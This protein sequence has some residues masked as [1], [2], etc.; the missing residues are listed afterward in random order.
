MNWY[1]VLPALID[2]QVWVAG[3]GRTGK[4]VIQA[5]RRLGAEIVLI[6][7]NSNEVPDNVNRL[8]AVPQKI[9]ADLIVTSPGWRPDHELFQAAARASVKVIGDVELAWLVD[10]AQ[11]QRNHRPPLKWLAVTG[12]NGKTTTVEMLESILKAGGIS[13]VACGNVGLPVIDAVM[14]E[15]NYQALAVELSSFEIFWAPSL[16]PYASAVLNISD[17]HL[18][19]HGS[20]E[21]Y[22]RTKISLLTHSEIAIYNADDAATV[23]FLAHEFMGE[24]I[25][26]TLDSPK[27]G[28]LGVVEDLLVDRAFVDNPEDEAAPLASLA[29]VK[30]FAPHNVSNA[31]AAAA[32]ARSVGIGLEAVT[33]GLSNFKS[34]AH[35]IEQIARI[36]EV[37]Y[38]DDSKATNPHAASASL[39]S[40]SSVVWIAG[41][42]AKGASM[43][44]LIEENMNRLRGVVLIGRDRELIREALMKFA[45]LVPVVEVESSDSTLSKSDQAALLMSKVIRTAGGLAN[46]GD[47]V[48]LAPACA[49][50]DQFDSYAERGD[51]FIQAV[52]AYEGAN[53]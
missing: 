22:A 47:T 11:A 25:S 26:F 8:K 33:S 44:R 38:V 17:D 28:Q 6:D 42:L 4:S 31:L 35:R 9:D 36:N 16:A 45:P 1:G 7:E 52:H 15:D 46:P 5:L 49:S 29:D 50:M 53:P 43:D 21:E 12:T 51:L 27:P 32:L 41:G 10:Q 18:D 13:A 2:K 20:I 24:R 40:F 39:R 23:A 30:P 34:G 14:A 48:L 3:Y 37:D 19:W